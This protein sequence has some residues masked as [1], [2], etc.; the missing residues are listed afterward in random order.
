[1]QKYPFDMAYIAPYSPRPGTK[2]FTMEETV[3][4]GEKKQRWAELTKILGQSALQQNQKYLGE[5]GTV[6]IGRKKRTVAMGR[7]P[8]YKE[9]EIHDTTVTIGDSI[10]IQITEAGAWR[11][12]GE[13]S[14]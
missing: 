1:M 5:K 8:N 7:L 6:L 12:V 10:T 3:T 13:K 11:L 9:V 14:P 4:R 2:A